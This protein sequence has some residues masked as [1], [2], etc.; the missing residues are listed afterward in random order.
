MHAALTPLPVREKLPAAHIPLPLLLPQP[1]RQYRPPGHALQDAF[2]PLPAVEKLPALHSP[3]P[4]D[5][6]QPARQYAPAGHAK[7]ALNAVDPLFSLYVPA[8]QAVQDALVP[9]PAVE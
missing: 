4:L 5:E 8:G 6:L 3:L 1:A 9:L 7:H 2:V